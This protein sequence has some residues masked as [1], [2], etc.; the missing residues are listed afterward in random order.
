MPGLWVF[1]MMGGHVA[2]NR[3][4]F[5]MWWLAKGEAWTALLLH[6][7]RK[8][9]SRKHCESSMQITPSEYPAPARRMGGGGVIC[10]ELGESPPAPASNPEF[11]PPSTSPFFFDEED[12]L[13][14]PEGNIAAS[15][16]EPTVRECP[17]FMASNFEDVPQ[18]GKSVKGNV[19]APP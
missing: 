6:L 17:A 8:D 9:S 10:L 1:K 19:K 12:P 3:D 7:C 2:I 15:S 4:I 13:S 16:S 18:D 14:E 11:L 5:V